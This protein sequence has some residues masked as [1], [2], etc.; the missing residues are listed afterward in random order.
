[1]SLNKQ[2]IRTIIFYE[3]KKGSKT[4]ETTRNI[5][6]TLGEDTVKLR[7]IQFWYKRFEAGDFSLEDKDRSG[8]PTEIDDE[9]ICDLLKCQSS[10]TAADIAEYIGCSPTSVRHRLTHLGY[11]SRLDKWVPHDLTEF[12]KL[13]RVGACMRLAA[14]Q[15]NEDFLDRVV[16][17]DEKWVYY[18]N[19]QRRRTWSLHDEPAGTVAKRALTKNK[20]LLCVWWDVKGIIYYEFLKS[21][22]TINSDIY[23]DQLDKVNENLKEKR[24]ALVNRKGF[25]FHQDNAKPHTSLQT[26]QKLKELGWELMEHPPYSP[27]IAPSDFHLFR[28]LQNFLSGAKFRSAEET[29]NAVSDFFCS[30]KPDFFKEGIYK[31]VQRWTDVIALNGEYLND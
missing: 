14:K 9:E 29:K 24:S 6:E 31:L 1:M 3:W 7:T 23:C 5:C 17:C 11:K 26:T 20:V 13:N 12:N 4:S 27:D 19:A 25:I 28:S 8:R 30:K 2:Q 10:L 21:G 22:E 16:T 18:D 15:K